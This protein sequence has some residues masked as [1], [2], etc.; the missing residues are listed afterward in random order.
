MNVGYKFDTDYGFE[1][2][3]SEDFYQ[4]VE[5]DDFY[6]M[7]LSKEGFFDFARKSP[8]DENV[9]E[10]INMK[11][12][13]KSYIS[14]ED[15]YT[16]AVIELLDISGALGSSDLIGFYL[17]NDRFIVVDIYDRDESTKKAFHNLI[18]KKFYARS[19]GRFF[20]HFLTSL[21]S[22]H[23]EIY[24][25]IKNKTRDVEDRIV[26][27]EKGKETIEILADNTHKVLDLYSSYERLLDYI[28]VLVENENEI[29]DEDDIKHIKSVAFRIDRYSSNISYLSNYIT[30]VKDSNASRMDLSL[31]NTMKILTV[32]TTIFTPITLLTGWYGMNFK[33]MPELYWD[34]G[35]IYVIVVSI[36]SVILGIYLFKKLDL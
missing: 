31:N 30:N 11:H 12:F 2:I 34:Y 28:E 8:I 17:E 3:K 35:Y 36:L 16:F 32:V 9:L 14:V 7:Y 21:I 23:T 29:F 5:D 1:K 19:P 26:R 20:K 4:L 22:N 15:T 25:D 10:A 33:V 6:V 18:S 27:N 24:D 13:V